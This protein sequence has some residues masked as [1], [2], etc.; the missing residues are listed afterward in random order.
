MFSRRPS[1]YDGR[2]AN[3]GFNDIVYQG[4]E[5]YT[6]SDYDGSVPYVVDEFGGIKW[7]KGQDETSVNSETESWGYGK[8]VVSIEDFYS[9]LEAQ[10]SALLSLSDHIWGYC[11]T[12]LTEVEQE[13]NGVY[14]YDRSSK[15]DISRIRAIFS[16]EPSRE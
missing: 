2:T 5:P 4:G 13:Q 1:T 15:F 7:V 12:Q 8:S 3:V 10:V 16:R 6:Y 11:Y 14:C 9:R